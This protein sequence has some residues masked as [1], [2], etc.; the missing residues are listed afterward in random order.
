MSDVRGEVDGFL[1]EKSGGERALE[2]LLEA[3][4]EGPWEF[5]DVDVDSGLFGELV[6][7]GIVVTADDGYRL[8]D[9]DAV[10]A[11]LSGETDDAGAGIA[12]RI[13][14]VSVSRPDV[15][16]TAVA[17]LAA[18]LLFLL[19]VRVLLPWNAV[20]RGS[21]VVLVGNDPWFYRYWTERLLESDLS[22]FDVG[23]LT[24][25]PDSL[26]AHDVL[27]VVLSW[28]SAA[29]LGGTDRAAGL[30][31][32]WYPPIAA[33]FSALL[34]YRIAVDVFDDVRV[35]LSAVFLLAVVPVHGYRTMLGFGDHHALDYVFIAVVALSLVALATNRDGSV[36][37]LGV[38]GLGVGV[39][40]LV[41]NWRGGPLF[42]FP[43]AIYTELLV[44]SSVRADTRPLREN[45]GLLAG[46]AV[47]TLLT[48]L[49]FFGLGWVE[50]FRAFAPALL[51]AGAVLVVSC[52][53]VF[54]RF[55]RSVS[56]A[57]AAS[58]A[59][60]LAG[61][62]LAWLFVPDVARAVEQFVIYM[63]QTS[64]RQI[65]ETMSLFS[66][67]LGTIFAPVLFFG[68]A[69]FLAVPGVA[70]AARRVFREH[71]SALLAV[72]TLTL[73]FFVLSVVQIRFL[74]PLSLFVSVFAGLGFV[75]LAARVGI[76]SRP[77]MFGSES[78]SRPT[79]DSPQSRSLRLPTGEEAKY[80]VVLFVLVASLG[81]VQTPVKMSQQTVDESTYRTATAIDDYASER[82]IEYPENYVLSQWSDVRIYNYFVNGHSRDYSYARDT[83]EK[84]LLSTNP[85]A[86]S[87]TFRT[88]PVG[89]VVTTDVD[90]SPPDESMYTR[91]HG[92]HGSRFDGVG[93]LS[94]FRLIHASPG[95][96]VKAFAF[97][98][99]ARI[100]GDAPANSTVTASAEIEVGATSFTYERRVQSS[101]NSRFSVVVP[102]PGEYV[103]AGERVQVSERAV[104][105]G[106]NVSV[107]G[108]GTENADVTVANERRS[109]DAAVD[110]KRRAK[111]GPAATGVT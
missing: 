9:R 95:G 37:K 42:V 46:L 38:L 14:S 4:A 74:G 98:P 88:H 17:G 49:A 43:V 111:L 104:L 30:V 65:A 102:Y 35:G 57:A 52:G 99:G 34:V 64:S 40:A 81:F 108:A 13:S 36:S 21:D 89:F 80:V 11:G 60:A 51:L 101:A 24:S 59:G 105:G 26:A 27:I 1:A 2:Q 91:L 25:L 82:R 79:G 71:H 75:A 28:W 50:A 73:Y 94:H 53:E 110:A 3:D 23:A 87:S 106:A 29:A 47:A 41:L 63:N 33:L 31:L 32:A 48:F 54:V 78:G 12:D 69:F 83:Y 76:T 96:A 68:L 97:V 109:N 100:V 20:F 66:G 62:A 92:H 5:A 22:A 84:F 45:V 70:W 67:D 107:G 55:G 15:D 56:E 58:V 72:T 18:A 6:D 86:W 7:R 85:G 61:G 44:L 10:Q 8:A 19:A 93:G 103:V 77:S 90:G 39:T 16:R